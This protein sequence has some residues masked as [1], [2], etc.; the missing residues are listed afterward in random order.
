MTP[1][2]VRR[3]SPIVVKREPRP[4]HRRATRADILARDALEAPLP[5]SLLVLL[6]RLHR[7]EV[8]PAAE[9]DSVA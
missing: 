7:A 5:G 2:F 4:D 6:S 3:R 9:S 8:K 1:R